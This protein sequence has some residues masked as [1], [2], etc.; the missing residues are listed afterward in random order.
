MRRHRPHRRDPGKTVEGLQE[1]LRHRIARNL[2]IAPDRIRFG[3]LPDGRRGKLNTVG[4]HW[5]IFYHG[6]W[7]ELPWCFDGPDGVTRELVRRWHG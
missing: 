3:P 7:R 5:Q 1:E 4:D 2:S 6:E